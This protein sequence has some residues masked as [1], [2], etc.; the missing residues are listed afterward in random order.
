MQRKTSTHFCATPRSR[1]R[2]ALRH[3]RDP[4]SREQWPLKRLAEISVQR[5]SSTS[6]FVFFTCHFLLVVVF[7]ILLPGRASST[8]ETEKWSAEIPQTVLP[9]ILLTFIF[10]HK[11]PSLK[12]WN[13][14]RRSQVIQEWSGSFHQ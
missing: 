12:G 5:I 6:L 10:H 4:P 7:Q 9:G 3:P 13:L 11:I 8:E 2:P 1:H 14:F